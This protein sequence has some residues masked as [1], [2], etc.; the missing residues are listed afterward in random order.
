MEA[1]YCS[2][3]ADAH[4]CTPPRA[5]PPDPAA[6]APENHLECAAPAPDWAAD[7]T[8]ARCW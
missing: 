1:D 2:L 7:D 6:R 3:R 4:R 8:A 5:P